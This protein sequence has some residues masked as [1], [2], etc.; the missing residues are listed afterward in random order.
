ML[1]VQRHQ[2]NV[3]I[4]P[5]YEQVQNHWTLFIGNARKIEICDWWEKEF[6]ANLTDLSKALDCLSHDLLMAE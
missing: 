6:G 3:I 4:I 5:V 2:K 1:L